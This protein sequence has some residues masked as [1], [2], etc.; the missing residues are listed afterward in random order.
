MESSPSAKVGKDSCSFNRREN[1]KSSKSPFKIPTMKIIKYSFIPTL[2]VVFLACQKEAVT[3]P[4][5][6]TG[7]EY[8]TLAPF[9]DAG[10]PTNVE[11][12][13]VSSDLLSFVT[14]TLPEQKDLRST[15]SSLLNGSASDI[16]LTKQSEVYLTFVSQGTIYKNAIAFYTYPTATPPASPKDIKT[17]T[18]VFPNAGSGTTLTAGSK[19]K[20]GTFEAGTSIGMVLLQ[21]AWNASTKKLNNDAVH[22]CYNDVLNPE[23]D[24]KLK[25][26]VVL[27]NYADENKILIGFEDIDRT[28][29]NCDHDFNDVV[30]YATIK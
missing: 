18:Y 1:Q 7:T 29:K 22:F 28:S 14:T 3:K 21:D 13:T 17:I 30:L 24:P 11:K 10:K 12:E 19:V 26:H 25:K 6:F 23:V 15:N 27:M 9:D 2:A 8:Q 20:L 16:N 4:V 5:Q